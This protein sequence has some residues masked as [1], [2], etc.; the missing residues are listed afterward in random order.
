MGFGEAIST[1]FRKY[2]EFNGRARR[3]EFWW[4]ALFLLLTQLAAGVVDEAVF[5]GRDMVEGLW[6]L[7]TFLPSLSVSVRRLHDVGKSGWWVLFGLIPVVGWIV[8]LVWYCQRGAEEANRFGGA[9]N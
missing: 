3:P 5:G 6:T 8:L 2:A 1:C 9:P 7:A 4:F